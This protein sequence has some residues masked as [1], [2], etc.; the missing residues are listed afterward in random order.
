MRSSHLWTPNFQRTTTIFPHPRTEDQL[1][2]N[3]YLGYY[4]YCCLLRRHDEGKRLPKV[5]EVSSPEVGTNV[6]DL[7]SNAVSQ[8]QGNTTVKY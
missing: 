5:V 2:V 6:V 1:L 8:E 4:R 3:I 7:F